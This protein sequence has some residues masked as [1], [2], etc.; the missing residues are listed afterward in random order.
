MGTF[1]VSLNEDLDKL[2]MRANVRPVHPLIL[3]HTNLTQYSR[4]L[5]GDAESASGDMNSYYSQRTSGQLYKV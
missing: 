5:K 2:Y 3:R 4:S 1:T